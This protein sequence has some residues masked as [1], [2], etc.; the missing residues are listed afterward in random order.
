[1]PHGRWIAASNL[2]S[3]SGSKPSFV[4]SSISL[5][6]SSKRMHDLLAEQ[7]RQHRDAEVDLLRLAALVEADLDA[8]V[9]RQPLLGDV[10][11]AT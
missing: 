6:L 5:S 2:A 10:E 1:M 11:L 9:L 8:A 7:R 3:D 4:M